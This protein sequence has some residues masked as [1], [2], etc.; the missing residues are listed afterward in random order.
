[1]PA[2][3]KDSGLPS[4]READ[5]TYDRVAVYPSSR[6]DECRQEHGDSES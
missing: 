1:M 4:I 6:D 5:Q 2:E 3:P